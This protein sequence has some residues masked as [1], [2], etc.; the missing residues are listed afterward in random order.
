MSD[1]EIRK[2]LGVMV[3]CAKLTPEIFAKAIEDMLKNISDKNPQ[4]KTSLNKLM[5]TGKVDSIEVSDSNIGSFTQTAK[6]YDLTY[7]LKRVQDENGKK[8]YLVCFHGKDLETMQKA[9]KEYSYKQTHKKETLF[10]R[11]KIAEIQVSAPEHDNDRSRSKQKE[12][13]KERSDK[14][15]SL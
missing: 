15:I 3:E 11:K 9:F 13:K 1:R 12:H 4:G 14:N 8:Q 10:S 5:K 2:T 7:A 6:K